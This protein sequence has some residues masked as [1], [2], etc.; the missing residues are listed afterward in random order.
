VLGCGGAQVQ[1]VTRKMPRADCPSGG[2]ARGGPRH[3]Q[4]CCASATMRPSGSLCGAD[5][6]TSRGLVEF[7]QVREVHVR[8]RRLRPSGAV[9]P[10]DQTEAPWRPLTP[11]QPAPTETASSG[12]PRPCMRL[13][14]RASATDRRSSGRRWTA[15]E[16]RSRWMRPSVASACSTVRMV[17]TGRPQ[18]AAIALGPSHLPLRAMVRMTVSLTPSIV[19]SWCI[20]SC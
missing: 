6:Q 3:G 9:W 15:N 4:Q 7:L 8:G 11:P 16:G 17:A 10:R 12:R 1:V 2:N 14:V 5:T 19:V 13:C 18:L 20:S